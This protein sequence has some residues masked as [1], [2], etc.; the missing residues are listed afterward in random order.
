MKAYSWWRN[1][2]SVGKGYKEEKEDSP[3]RWRE[4]PSDYI[5]ENMAAKQERSAGR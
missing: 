1:W 4:D 5:R 3:S 2:S